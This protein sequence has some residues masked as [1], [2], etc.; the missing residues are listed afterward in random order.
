L[1]NSAVVWTYCSRFFLFIIR[2]WGIGN[3][4]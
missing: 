3:R 2:K 1:I 4:E